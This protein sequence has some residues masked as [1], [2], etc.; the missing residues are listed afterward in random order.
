M[1]WIE[2][3]AV[4][5]KWPNQVELQELVSNACFHKAYETAMQL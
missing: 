1:D 5:P 3:N 2:K 4:F